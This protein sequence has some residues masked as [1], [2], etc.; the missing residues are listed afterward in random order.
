MIEIDRIYQ[1][2]LKMGYEPF[3]LD[4]FSKKFMLELYKLEKKRKSEG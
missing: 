4:T 3:A 1:E 2:M